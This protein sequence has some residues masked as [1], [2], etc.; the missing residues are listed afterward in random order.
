VFLINVSPK[1]SLPF[2]EILD[3]DDISRAIGTAIKKK[4]KFWTPSVRMNKLFSTAVVHNWF[5]HQSIAKG[6]IRQSL[7]PE[8]RDWRRKKTRAIIG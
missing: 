7:S 2:Q 3:I 6:S 8:L 5:L 4:C 1:P